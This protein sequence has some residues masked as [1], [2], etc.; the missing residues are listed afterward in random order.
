MTHTVS[1]RCYFSKNTGLEKVEKLTEVHQKKGEAELVQV[2]WLIQAVLQ[3][4]PGESAVSRVTSG[5]IDAIP[6]HLLQCH[7]SYHGMNRTNSST[8]C[9]LFFKNHMAKVIFTI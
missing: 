1:L 3:M 6:I 4:K 9:L 7:F 5:D 2:A 8:M